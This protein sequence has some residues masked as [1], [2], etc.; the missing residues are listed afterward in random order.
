MDENTSEAL[1]DVSCGSVL[2]P[3][4]L[5]YKVILDLALVSCFPKVE[6]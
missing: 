6:G 3:D 1:Q 2:K 5:D 4:E